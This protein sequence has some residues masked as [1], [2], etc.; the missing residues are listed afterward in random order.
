M[1]S[2]ILL[3][4]RLVQ[5]LGHLNIERAH[6]AACMPRDWEGLVAK[7]LLLVLP[8]H[9]DLPRYRLLESERIYAQEQLRQAEVDQWSGDRHDNSRGIRN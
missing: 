9:D 6:F 3:E 7:H 5:L 2:N 8:G 1:S 4:D